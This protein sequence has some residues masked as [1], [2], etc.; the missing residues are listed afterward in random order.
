MKLS[1]IYSVLVGTFFGLAV[2]ACGAYAFQK[3]RSNVAASEIVVRYVSNELG[4][5][6]GMMKRRI[7]NKSE[8]VNAEFS[9][10]PQLEVMA[11][12]SWLIY[13]AGAKSLHE[14]GVVLPPGTMSPEKVAEFPDFIGEFNGLNDNRIN[15]IPAR[16]RYEH[17]FGVE[18][19]SSEEL[20]RWFMAHHKEIKQSPVLKEP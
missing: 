9:Y 2:G 15:F 4:Y 14:K 12:N 1:N 11:V 17:Y 10:W 5:F 20:I 3:A 19:G 7:S 6:Q 8:K 18:L 16:K 13:A